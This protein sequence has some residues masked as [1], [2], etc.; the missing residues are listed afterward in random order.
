MIK[1][2]KVHFKL[3]D[4][5]KLLVPQCRKINW[6]EKNWQKDPVLK[7]QSPTIKSKKHYCMNRKIFT[8]PNQECMILPPQKNSIKKICSHNPTTPTSTTLNINPTPISANINSPSQ[9]QIEL[10]NFMN[11]WR[12]C[13]SSTKIK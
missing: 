11:A 8:A 13:T 2:D 6:K 10:C 7:L 9:K 12:I 1:T 5:D 3:S 4:W